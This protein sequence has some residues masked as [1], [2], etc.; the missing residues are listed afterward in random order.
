MTPFDLALRV[1]LKCGPGVVAQVPELLERQYGFSSVGLVVDGRVLDAS[2]Q[3]RAVVDALRNRFT[4]HVLLEYR[5]PFE[6]TYGFLD[7]CAPMFRKEDGPAVDCI[8][9]VGGGSALD[10]A[11]GLATLA[12]N[13]GQ[14]IQY[15]GFPTNLRPSLPTVAVPTTAGTGSEV[16]F[17]AVFTDDESQRKLGINTPSNY[18]LLGILDPELVINAPRAV[19]VS[20]GLDALVHTL[21]G[22]VSIKGSPLSR[23]F[24]SAAFER[25]VRHLPRLAAD[26]ASVEDAM[27][28][29][30]GAV[31]AMLGMSNSSSGPSGGLSYYLGTHFGVPHGLAGAVFIGH[32]MEINHRL[33]FHGLGEVAP[34]LPGGNGGG[35]GAERSRRAVAAIQ[36]LLRGLG[37]PN[38]LTP[39]GVRPEH[40]PG[41]FEFATVTLQGAFGLNPVAVSHDEIRALLTRLAGA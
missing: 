31:L 4:N 38:D 36:A 12:T 25:I 10:T 1:S 26:R 28:M 33:G 22:Y 6:P 32:M 34:L 29:Q 16:V 5:E 3:V 35:S 19:I 8:V 15:R 18:P 30:L 20:S 40:V 2:P 21:E 23:G 17:N 13:P 24:S 14:A 27:E 39:F 9:G 41:F 7:R 11:K 37:V